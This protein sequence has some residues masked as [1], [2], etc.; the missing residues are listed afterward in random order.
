VR[1]GLGGN[2]SVGALLQSDEQHKRH[3]WDLA[4]VKTDRRRA[5]IRA[6]RLRCYREV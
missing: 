4:T 6:F 1:I 5:D 2:S 3:L